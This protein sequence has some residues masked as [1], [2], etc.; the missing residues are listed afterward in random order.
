MRGINPGYA[1]PLYT[2]RGHGIGDFSGSF[3]RWLQHLMWRVTKA[4]SRER[5]RT[6]DK[7]LTDIAEDKLPEL[8][9]NDIVPK[10]VTEIV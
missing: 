1:A 3:F 7:I 5:L 6:G 9:P 8:S 10:H 2:R 4:V